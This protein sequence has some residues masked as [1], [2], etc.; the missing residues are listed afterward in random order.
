MKQR[1]LAIGLLCAC[2]HA[3]GGELRTATVNNG[4][5]ITMQRMGAEFERTH[6]GTRLTWVTMEEGAL[7]QQIA[8]DI[9]TRKGRFD[10]MTIGVLEAPIWGR[11]GWL[12]PV[13]DD[14]AYQAFDLLPAIRQSL[15]DNG[16]LYA[17]P[18]YGES[19]M[20]LY[21]T[22]LFKAAGLSMPSQPTWE[23]IKGFAARLHQPAK[24]VYGLCLRGKPGWGE[25]MT[26]I[27]PMVNSF[28]GQW[29]N[30]DWRPQLDTRPWLDA[31]RL[32]TELLNRYGPPAA[33]ANG[34]NENL[35]LFSEGR[36]AMWV[37]A[38]VA[39]G[40]VNRPQGSRVAGKVGFVRAPY[41]T[42][43]KGAHWLWA[44]ALAVPTSSRQP[45]EAMAFVKWA[46]SKAYIDLVARSEGWSAVPSG[47][48]LSTYANPAF[49]KA[50]PHAEVER[51]G[52]A[53]ADPN[54]ST[55][56]PS[57]YTG[58]QLAVIPEFQAIGTAVGQ[59]IAAILSEGVSV[60]D[61]LGRA[62]QAA[63]RKMRE[64]GYLK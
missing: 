40:F 10:V 16:V 60:E 44:W 58:V 11:R 45:D 48:R 12:R 47:T 30:M 18:F 51:Q 43:P 4:H 21:R 64:A 33:V 50:N 23:Q 53:S 52:I 29:F 5:M 63:E 61:A 38:S 31:V 57:P 34:Y 2:V 59:Q 49:I 15:S 56:P 46:T 24:G 25:N 8:T 3:L 62:Q 36:C 20:T 22:D 13:P 14:P 27:T 28:G 55:V 26:L 37:D 9:A 39:G 1:V 35:V 54:D 19:S 7:R 41:G 6:P 17:S 42:S 32:Y